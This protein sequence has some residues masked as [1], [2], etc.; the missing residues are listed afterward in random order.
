LLKTKNKSGLRTSVKKLSYTQTKEV[1]IARLK[2]VTPTHLNLGLH[3]L[4]ASG[5]SA[6]ANAG[7]NERCFKRHGRWSSS[8]VN[9]YIKDYIQSVKGFQKFGLVTEFHVGFNNCY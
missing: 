7:V 6:A 2:E 9:G 5:V 4:R 1:F 3:T 8:A